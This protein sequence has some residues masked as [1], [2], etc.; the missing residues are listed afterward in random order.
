MPK[1]IKS[2]D[3]DALAADMIAE[4]IQQK[5]DAVLGLATGSTPIGIYKKLIEKNLDFS[6]VRTFN[7]DEYVGLA[8]SHPQSYYHFMQENL[9]KHTNIKKENIN[10]LN[11]LASDI[12]KETARY[13]DLMR[14]TPIDIQLLGIGTNGHIAFNEPGSPQDST[15][16]KIVLTQ[17]T[18]KDNSRFFSPGE[19]QPEEALSMGIQ[20]IMAAKQIILIAKGQNKT[21]AIHTA[22]YGP[23]TT[24]CPA[25]FLQN[26]RNCI[27]IL[28][29]HVDI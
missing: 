13:E 9:F 10:F 28:D 1:L 18:I 19:K 11:G 20:S 29:P 25:S 26:H 8:Q 6:R 3:P 16:R 5:P 22:L 15:S 24:D 17:Q 2:Q 14:Q 21:K 7:L 12:Q 27:F 23:S 4:F